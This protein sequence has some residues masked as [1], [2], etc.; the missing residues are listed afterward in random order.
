LRRPVKIKEDRMLVEN[1]VRMTLGI[2]DHRVT[3]VELVGGEVRI[4]LAAKKGRR[5]P[6]SVCGG[7]CRPRDELKERRW[8]HV[9]VW[10][11]PV[12]LL[13][14]PRRVVCPSH[15]IKVERIPWSIGK[16]RVSQPL[17]TVLAFWARLLPWDQVA[18]LFQVRWGSVR[19]AVAAAVAYGREQEPYHG[20][21]YIGIDEISRKKGHVYHTNVYDLE[22]KRLIWSGAHRD[23][24]SL[25]RFF[26]WWGPERTAAIVGVCC[27][28]WQNY[29]DV[30][31]ECCT[32]AV[33]VFDKFHI[34]RHLMEAVDKVRR[35]E[36][37]VLAESGDE[38]LKRTRYVW[39]K[40]PWNLTVRQW[41]TLGEL[42]R[43]N[44]KTVKAYLLKEL[45]RKLWTYTRRAW[46]AKY[47]KRWF[48]WATHSRLK[49]LRDFAWM[50]R[51]HEE[52]ILAYFELKRADG[53]RLSNGLTEAMNNNAKAISHRAR[54]YRSEITYSLALIH[55][56]GDL[57]L[58]QSLHRFW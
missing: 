35:M 47:L 58:P 24:D 42:L 15:G 55:G 16:Q 2:K 6:C 41:A 7:R 21:R 31:Q 17:I 19:S 22:R 32:S 8:R 51:R 49:P 12:F 56:L 53:T 52:G 36:A 25:R 38:S 14:R 39:L 27:D 29:I 33:I 37:R 4:G 1:I 10:G 46:A 3:R 11:M 28:M 44:L 26:A 23:K 50:L 20:V 48:W 43:M 45:F 40:N 57:Q 13:Y 34:V 18:T 5:L 9:S 30:V 54:G